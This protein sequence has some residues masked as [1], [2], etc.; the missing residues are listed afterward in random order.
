MFRGKIEYTFFNVV[1]PVKVKK[2]LTLN[3][4]DQITFAS[5]TIVATNTKSIY[6]I[7]VHI[8]I[9][10]QTSSNSLLFYTTIYIRSVEVIRNTT[11]Y[12]CMYMNELI[13]VYIEENQSELYNVREKFSFYAPT[14]HIHYTYISIP[15]RFGKMERALLF[16]YI[17]VAFAQHTP[18]HTQFQ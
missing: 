13:N 16:L 9:I 15:I 10:Y 17:Y 12:K 4:K 8:I 5:N 18:T 3:Y 11:R 1:N 14:F 2:R 7:Q 6:I